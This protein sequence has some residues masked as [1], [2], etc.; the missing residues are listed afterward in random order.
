VI[1]GVVAVRR[2]LLDGR[3]FRRVGRLLG[4]LERITFGCTTH[5]DPVAEQVLRLGPSDH[6][7]RGTRSAGFS[8]LALLRRNAMSFKITMRALAQGFDA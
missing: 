3:T 5:H 1:V 6:D 2:W 7:V 8:V 4:R